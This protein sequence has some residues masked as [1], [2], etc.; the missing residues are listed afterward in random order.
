MTAPHRKAGASSGGE[1]MGHPCHEKL[2]AL[3]GLRME[4]GFGEVAVTC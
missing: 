4:S 1:R 3:I 2:E